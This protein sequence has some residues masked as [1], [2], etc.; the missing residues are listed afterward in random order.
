MAFKKESIEALRLIFDGEVEL[1]V[2]R[3]Q[4]GVEGVDGVKHIIF[5]GSGKGGVGKSTVSVNLAI[6]LE[7]LGFS[8]G[9]M[10]ADIYGPSIPTMMGKFESPEVL[11]GEQLLPLQRHGVSF[12]SAGSLIPPGKALDWRGQLV[13]GT[14]VQFI[15][16]TCW[17]ELDFLIVDLPP[18]TG[19]AQLTLASKLRTAGVVLVTTP[20]EVALGDVRRAL[21]LF[22]KQEVPVLGIVENM[23][24]HLCESCGHQNHPFVTSQ[25]ATLDI[26][27]LARLPLLRE[28]SQGADNGVPVI[29]ENPESE[30]SI[31]FIAMARRLVE[32]TEAFQVKVA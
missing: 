12:I 16:Q 31:A 20:Q 21:D 14:L 3:A 32:I 24:W 9:L 26:E 13:S 30:A 15:K 10:D 22:H 23:A 19:D 7:K 4:V 11:P 18:G 8:V 28:I 5:V 2:N 29:L 1:E 17:G 27:V 6:A 25:E